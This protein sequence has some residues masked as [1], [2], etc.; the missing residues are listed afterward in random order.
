[1]GGDK[2]LNRSTGFNILTVIKIFI[3]Y[4]TWLLDNPSVF[5]GDLAQVGEIGSKVLGCGKET[6]SEA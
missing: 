3:G 6:G 2:G 1:V 4:F 5:A